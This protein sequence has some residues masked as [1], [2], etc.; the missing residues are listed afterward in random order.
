[1]D[2]RLFIK[3]TT[4]CYINRD[5]GESYERFL[6]RGYFVVSQKFTTTDE[7]EKIL[8]YSRIW[9]NIKYNKCKYN[10]KVLDVISK[11]ETNI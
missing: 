5:I 1:M 3:N 2:K 6:E 11:L 9:C 4:Y 10:K 8:L 7:F